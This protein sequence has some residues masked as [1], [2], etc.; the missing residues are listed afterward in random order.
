MR[1]REVTH[2][3]CLVEKIIPLKDIGKGGIF[4]GSG[5][6]SDKGPNYGTGNCM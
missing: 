3:I 4:Q 6:K 1:P 5:K 2:R